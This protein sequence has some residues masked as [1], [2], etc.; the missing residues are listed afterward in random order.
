MAGVHMG[1]SKEA[2]C[3]IPRMSELPN[4]PAYRQLRQL[5]AQRIAILDGAMGTMIRQFRLGRLN[6]AARSSPSITAI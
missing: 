4:T 6:I 2:R 5:L 1:V 3:Q